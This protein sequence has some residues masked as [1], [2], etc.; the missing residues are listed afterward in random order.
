[1]VTPPC[2]VGR[3]AVARACTGTDFTSPPAKGFERG[4]SYG[5]HA[6]TTCESDISTR[7]LDFMSTPTSWSMSW[8]ESGSE[9]PARRRFASDPLLAALQKNSVEDTRIACEANSDAA[10]LPFF[11]HNFEPPLCAAARLQCSPDVVT[12]L[13]QYGA[14]VHKC[15]VHGKGPLAVLLNQSGMVPHRRELADILREAGADEPA[16]VDKDRCPGHIALNSVQ[17]P[18]EL[19]P[20]DWAS[21]TMPSLSESLRMPPPPPLPLDAFTIDGAFC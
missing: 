9:R 2:S 4:F 15:D 5:S 13:L 3:H 7:S 11:D 16:V 17:A 1:M 19:P 20:Q 10:T 6:S 12:L 18:W 21:L 14:D 8:P